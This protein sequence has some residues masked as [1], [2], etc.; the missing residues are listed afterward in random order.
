[1]KCESPYAAA[2]NCDHRVVVERTC[3]FQQGPA[4]DDMGRTVLAAF[5][6]RM[7][8]FECLSCGVG[9]WPIETARRD[10]A[11][12]VP[13]CTYPTCDCFEVGG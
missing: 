9:L 3:D 6:V 5:V 1:M 4:F 10:A 7:R 12:K 2:P 11:A 13:R 8:I